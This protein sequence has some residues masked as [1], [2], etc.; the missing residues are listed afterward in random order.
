[1]V[2][3]VEW[4]GDFVVGG[5]DG[6]RL[7]PNFRLRELRRADGG[8]R[9]H[10]ELV[11]ALQIL[12]NRFGRPVA[13]VD[14]D[15]D[16][17]GASVRGEPSAELAAAAGALAGRG[18]F[19]SIEEA[20]G[21]IRARIPDPAALPEIDLEEALE[22]AFTVTSGFET[23]GDRFQQ[24]T[25]NFDGAGL[26]FGPAQVNFGTGTLV[27]LFRELR[28]ADEPALRACFADPIDW[29]EWLRVLDLPRPGQIAWA[30]G[31]STGRGKHDLVEPWKGYLR[32][33]G[34]LEVFRAVMVESVLRKYGRAL[35]R[36]VE[37]LRDLRPEVTIDH[38]RCVC[39]L[40]DLVIQQGSLDK[41]RSR[42]EERVAAED[43]RDQFDLVR[44]AVEERG[45][46]A[47]SEF[48]SDCLSR[49]LGI[50]AGVPET[51]GGRQRTNVHFYMLRDV[52]VRRA[53]ELV[54]ANVDEQLARVSRA[55]ASGRSLLA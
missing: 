29:E 43:P 24:V 41:A 2:W 12:R 25:G 3:N 26:S 16:G 50:L 47:R 21:A 30:D 34:R 13:V 49:R 4:Q 48:V 7:T 36:E 33:V 15:A 28:E 9:V 27:P 46:T 44:I 6:R 20:D 10:R 1:M 35:V 54:D 40:Y 17:L 55:L 45:R 38:L 5:D 42:I 19:R 32:A 8:V 39:S 51:V 31:V 14:T 18:L 11:S 22:S 53:R 23:S 37:Y 52:R